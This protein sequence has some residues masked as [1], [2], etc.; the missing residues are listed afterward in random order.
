MICQLFFS[1]VT[2]GV[3]Y[4]VGYKIDV[5][6]AAFGCILHPHSTCP[7]PF[8]MLCN[9]L[10]CIVLACHQ[11]G[12]GFKSPPKLSKFSKTLLASLTYRWDHM[13]KNQP[14]P[15][16][17]QLVQGGHQVGQFQNGQNNIRIP[18]PLEHTSHS[19]STGTKHTWT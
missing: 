3:M 11:C 2:V 16:D 4:S 8:L 1:H 14:V 10:I 6:V 5:D 7:L 12:L 15:M 9:K 13:S 19:K 18:H 17:K